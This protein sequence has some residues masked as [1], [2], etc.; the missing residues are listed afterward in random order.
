MIRRPKN[1]PMLTSTANCEQ[2][3]GFVPVASGGDGD[4]IQ[5][6]YVGYNPPGMKSLWLIKALI[7]SLCEYSLY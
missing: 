2:T 7:L 1:H 5:Y 3:A 4:I 6:W